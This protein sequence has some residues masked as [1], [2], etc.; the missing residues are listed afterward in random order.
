MKYEVTFGVDLCAYATQTV[1]FDHEPTE[2]EVLEW[3][4]RQYNSGD[5]VFYEEWGTATSA[6][7][8]NVYEA[9]YLVYTDL[10]LIRNPTMQGKLLS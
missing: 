6:R 3:A 9:S 2:E 4:R 5:L 10:N 1:E 8:V 7:V